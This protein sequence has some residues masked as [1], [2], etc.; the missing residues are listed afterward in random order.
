MK[1]YLLLSAIA[2]AS[3]WAC[4]Y[5]PNDPEA[6]IHRGGTTI[7]AVLSETRSY[8][9][10][11]DGTAYPNYWAAGDVI[12]INGVASDPLDDSFAGKSEA[13]F[14]IEGVSAPYEAVYPA[15]AVADYAT[16]AA[17]L[18]LP[19][20]QNYVAGSYDP[21]AFIMLAKND[22]EGTLAF[23]PQ[24]ALFKFTA[25]GDAN[26]KSVKLIA[27]SANKLSGPFGTDFDIFAALEGASNIV[28]LSMPDGGVAPGTPMIMVIPA[29]DYTDGIG[30]VFTDVNGGVMARR[31]TPS[32]PYEAGKMY[33][34]NI[35]YEAAILF[36]TADVLT[37]SSVILNW[38]SINPEDNINRAFDLMVYGDE[39]CSNLLETYSIPANAACWNPD[40]K[41]WHLHFV[42]GGLSQGTQYWFKVKDKTDNSI[43]EACTATTT[44]FTP[45]AMPTTDISTTGVVFA[46]D[47][48]E[49]AWGWERITQAGGYIPADLSSLSNH[50]TEG[51]T[52][53]REETAANSGMRS[54]DLS[55][56]LS[57]SRLDGWLSE[58]NTYYHPG[59]LKLGSDNNYG[60]ALTPKFPI[61]EDNEAT[62]DVTLTASRYGDDEYETW[63]VCVISN[64][65]D[66]GGRQSDFAWPDETNPDVYREVE[67]AN[68]GAEWKTVT[69]EGLKIGRDNRLAFGRIKGGDKTKA[70]VYL[71][72][73]KV[74]VTGI[75]EVIPA[76]TAAEASGKTSS[77]LIFEWDGKK[78]HAFT[79]TLYSD[80]ACQN[81]VSSFELPADNSSIWNKTNPTY[82]FGGLTPNTKY[83]FKVTDT[84]Y[85]PAVV[86]NVV[87]ATTA[88]FNIVQMPASITGAGVVLAEDFGEI[89]WNADM[90]AKATG[91]VPS[92]TDNFSD[93]TVANFVAGNSNSGEKKWSTIT[94]PIAASRLNGWSVDS[95]VY[96]HCGNLKMGTASGK[97]WILTPPFPVPGGKKAKVNVTVTAARYNGDQETD[98]AVCVLNEELANMQTA[99]T[100]SFS[101]PNV[102]TDANYQLV[103]LSGTGW[104]TKTVEGLEVYAGDRITFGAKNGC[105]NNAGRIFVG[106]I[107]VEVT[108]V[109]DLEV[110]PITANAL[111]VTSSTL[112]F[113]W[114]EGGE[115]ADDADLAYTATLFSD[116]DCTTPVLSYDFAAGQGSS[117]WRNKYPKFIFA[118]LTAGTQYYFRVTDGAGQVSNVVAAKTDAFTVVTMPATITETGVALAEDFSLFV[119]D[120]EYGQ[121]CVGIAA[122]DSP[123]DFATRGT[124][125]IV[126][127]ESVG[128]YQVFT[129]P[130]FASSRLNKWARDKGTD[131]R[132]RVHPG[133][134]TLGSF[135]NNQKSWLLTP[136]FPVPE[137][138]VATV[139]I[140]IT[141]RKGKSGA[142]GDYA[143][144]ILNN[145]SNGGSAGGGQN[146]QDENTSDFSWPSDRTDE[147]YHTF[148]VNND[149]SWQTFTYTGMTIKA[150]DRV[151][152]GSRAGYDY[153]KKQSCLNLSDITVTVTAIEDAE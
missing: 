46:E 69:V 141:A 100:A 144:G 79:A 36:C 126:F 110:T 89:Q 111:E 15:V 52:F 86:S 67:F 138:K 54:A 107:K 112:S 3:A 57:D 70:R 66:K 64:D 150:G 30:V 106:D 35:D 6:P 127:S 39:A 24:M 22:S 87:E 81:V 16:G 80:A 8:L 51:A 116:A 60:Y 132:V 42:I 143:V 97:G 101:W 133:H 17:E 49:Y 37:S 59:Y 43:S 58:G 10:D 33:S 91:F 142:T 103:T 25:S 47:F 102:M 12:N 78:D 84:S 95:G 26:I 98:W 137:G 83:Y 41:N 61:A 121:G 74:E 123:T 108:A 117:L 34:T 40:L 44:A 145:S 14:T 29:G 146:M 77:T 96:Y 56:A 7:K 4:T 113:T 119:W 45:V 50:S 115:A 93:K 53:T 65:G 71:S 151:V 147:I 122:P 131:A 109:E 5:E 63:M 94:T 135:S 18:T 92:S 28:T 31:A 82:V 68:I 73:I 32:K 1:K 120:F 85:S 149:T 76:L 62:V 72:E 99:Y 27:S 136:P 124:D 20:V 129:S 55:T 13:E 140:K 139:T 134:I 21:A 75:S 152:V 88:E 38:S 48:S 118:G 125:P 114:N 105:A 2:L 19:A 130:A 23:E 128:S 90:V 153:S 11:K 148:T 104:Q 9:G